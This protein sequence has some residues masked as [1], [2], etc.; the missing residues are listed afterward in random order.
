MLAQRHKNAKLFI[1]YPF[2]PA[3]TVEQ[4]TTRLKGIVQHI[5]DHH[6]VEGL[7]GELPDRMQDV[8]D[9]EGDRINK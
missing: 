4:Y 6:D 5:N 7:C 2:E 3:Q 8:V 9:K 1:E